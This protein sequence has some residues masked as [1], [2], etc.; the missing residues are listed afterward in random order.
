MNKSPIY[1]CPRCGTQEVR[2]INSRPANTPVE[3][4]I[5]RR[6][7]CL[8]CGQRWTTYEITEAAYDRICGVT[9]MLR[10]VFPNIRRRRQPEKQ[11][12]EA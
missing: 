12:E 9:G 5:R 7:V 11:T 6:R 3:P 1:R 4:I 10:E 8:A 2:V